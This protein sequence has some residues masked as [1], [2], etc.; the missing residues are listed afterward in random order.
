MDI[1]Y[2]FLQMHRLLQVYKIKT[3]VSLYIFAFHHVILKFI[4]FKQTI[5]KVQCFL[6]QEYSK[7][8]KFGV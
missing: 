6:S 4:A 5:L 2:K 1:A 8:K 3:R 7:R